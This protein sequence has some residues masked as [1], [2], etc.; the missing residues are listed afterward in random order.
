MNIMMK[1]NIK[2]NGNNNNIQETPGNPD[3]QIKFKIHVQNKI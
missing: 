2:T 1:I 3:L